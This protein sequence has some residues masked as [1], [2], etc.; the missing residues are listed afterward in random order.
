MESFFNDT[1]TGGR[2]KADIEVGLHD[3]IAVILSNMSMEQDRKVR[4]D[5][6]DNMGKDANPQ[7]ME[8]SLQ[9]AEADYLKSLANKKYTKA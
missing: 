7:D 3:S 4:F 2:P 5:E 6:I 9:T 1:R 8:S